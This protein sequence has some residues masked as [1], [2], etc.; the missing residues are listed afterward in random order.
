MAQKILEGSSKVQTTKQN[1]KCK[2]IGGGGKIDRPS[3]A[4][5]VTQM[6]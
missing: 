2:K 6:S 3:A 5:Q 1:D 4:S